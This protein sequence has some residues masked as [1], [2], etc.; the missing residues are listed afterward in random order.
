MPSVRIVGPG[1]AGHS[2]ARA[3]GAAGW[4]VAAVVGRADHCGNAAQDVDL[5]LICTPDDA[6][7]TVAALIQP[8][9]AVVAHAAGSL[10]LAVLAP[11]ERTA[12]V[13]PLV[14]MPNPDIGAKRL[15]AKCWFA[16]A[17]H[18]L[19][20]RLVQDLGGRSFAVAE[21]DRA[22]YHAAACVAANHVVALVGQAERLATGVGVPPGAYVSL[23]QSALNDVAELGPGAALTG[24]IARG[25][26]ATLE[27]HRTVL[28]PD[29]LAT[30]DAM[31]SETE[32]LA[33]ERG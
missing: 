14:S 12:A 31:V 22:L 5:V 13:H 27:R 33:A 6:I 1:R 16:T 8:G 19:V 23:A 4:S 2:F 29:E 15:A 28:P 26:S 32:R 11:H 7:A 30:Y 25:D 18:E 3:L 9:P 20:D 24:P 17:G 10:G 21:Q